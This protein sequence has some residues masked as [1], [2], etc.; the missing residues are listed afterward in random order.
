MEISYHDKLIEMVY[1][2]K[3]YFETEIGFEINQILKNQY[4]IKNGN[5]IGEIDII[6]EG[7][8][9]KIA[10]IEVKESSNLVGHFL[11]HQYEKYLRYNPEA[12]IYLIVGNKER[13]VNPEEIR[14]QLYYIP[15]NVAEVK[16]K[17]EEELEI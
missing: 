2:N 3:K 12:Y 9:N 13:T 5:T 1:N 15:N 8:D 4:I 6:V 7:L 11:H 17:L 16:S 14:L 10:L